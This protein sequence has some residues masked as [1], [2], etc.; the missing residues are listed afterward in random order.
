MWPEEGEASGDKMEDR[1][2]IRAGAPRGGRRVVRSQRH[3]GNH[4]MCVALR[5]ES[6]SRDRCW[7]CSYSPFDWRPA[8]L[9]KSHEFY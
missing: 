5:G 7:V 1:G 3:S 6:G 4:N 2:L 8:G 9:P